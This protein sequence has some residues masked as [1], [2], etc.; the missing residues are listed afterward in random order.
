MMPLVAR[1]EVTLREWADTHGYGYDVVRSWR[2]WRGDFPSK[3]RMA[4]RT[5]LYFEA[6]LNA[7]KRRYPNLGQGLGWNRKP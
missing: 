4:G 3:S 7:W 1:R 6:D 2:Q 5:A